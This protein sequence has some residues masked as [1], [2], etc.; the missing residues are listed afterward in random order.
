[1]APVRYLEKVPVATVRMRSRPSIWVILP[2]VRSTN[3]RNPS[4]KNSPDESLAHESG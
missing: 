4:A 3:W 2:A 1:M